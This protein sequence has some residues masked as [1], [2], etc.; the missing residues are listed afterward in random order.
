MNLLDSLSQLLHKSPFLHANYSMLVHKKYPLF[1]NYAPTPRPRFG[2]GQPPHAALYEI[3]NKN[4]DNY[5]VLLWEFVTYDARFRRISMYEPGKKGEPFWTNGWF[6]S[7]DAIALYCF[8]CMY[9][10]ATYLEIGSGNSTKFVR[11]AI[12]DSNLSAKLVSI[13]P[14][15]RAEIDTL[16]DKVIRQPLENTDI[17]TYT[18]LQEN[19]ILFFDGSHRCF[20]NSDVTVFFLEVL[21]ALR[22]GVLCHFHD[23]FLP[24]DYPPE[25]NTKYYSEQYLLAAYLLAGTGKFDIMLPNSL[26]SHD[27]QLLSMLKPLAGYMTSH[28]YSNS[29]W[30]KIK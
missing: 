15:P 19:D 6:S 16:C 23:I 21:P 25:W 11:R 9:K 13:D 10:P 8:I 2:F 29:F 3:I 30:I 24:Y 18:D 1:V 22:P 4:R 7:L 17:A 14:Q 12:A 5:A 27:P 28:N 26:I 20:T